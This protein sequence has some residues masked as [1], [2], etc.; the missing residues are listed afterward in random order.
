VVCPCGRSALGAPASL[1]A[2]LTLLFPCRIPALQEARLATRLCVEIVV[3]KSLATQ[4]NTSGLPDRRRESLPGSSS[5]GSARFAARPGSPSATSAGARKTVN[6]RMGSP[7]EVS[8]LIRALQRRSAS[9]SATPGDL[10]NPHQTVESSCAGLFGT[11]REPHATRRDLISTW[12]ER[13][14]T[15]REAVGTRGDLISTSREAVGTSREAVGTQ[16]DPAGTPGE[17]SSRCKE[18]AS[19]SNDLATCCAD[20][21]GRPGELAS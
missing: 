9:R 14:G 18:V 7:L 13:V 21:C 16:A 17:A 12:R 1:P 10:A 4:R 2:G 19:C 3:L 20:P 5:G 6:S 8:T 15:T 11:T